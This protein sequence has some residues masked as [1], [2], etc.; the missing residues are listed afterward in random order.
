[1]AFVNRA[2][3]VI[4]FFVDYIWFFENNSF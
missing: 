1:M 2:Y 4:L 3:T